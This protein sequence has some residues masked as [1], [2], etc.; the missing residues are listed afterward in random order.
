MT[1]K[2]QDAVVAYLGDHLQHF[3]AS[4][5][6]YAMAQCLFH[7]DKSPSLSITVAT[8][9]YRCFGCGAKGDLAQLIEKLEGVSLGTAIHKARLLRQGVRH[10]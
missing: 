10:D 3:H 6:G 1:P 9:N 8:G 2:K 7:A 4:G 5:P